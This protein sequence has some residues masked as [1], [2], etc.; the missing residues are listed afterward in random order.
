MHRG[1]HWLRRFVA[2]VVISIVG[3]TFVFSEDEPIEIDL[4]PH[5]VLDALKSKFA[6]AE[7]I[8]ANKKEYVGRTVYQVAM[9]LRRQ[10]LTASIAENGGIL[11]VNKEIPAA[12]V[13]DSVTKAVMAMHPGATISMAQEVTEIKYL[14]TVKT[15][16]G[17]KVEL[18]VDPSGMIDEPEQ[19]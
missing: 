17:E 18:S 9:V 12:E 1:H 11:E 6:R 13:P 10:K 14:V 7:L 8:N 3:G 19:D 15:E 16:T 4:L 2:V 5:S